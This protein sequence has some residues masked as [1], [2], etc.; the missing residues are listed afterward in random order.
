MNVGLSS[1]VA[2]AGRRIMTAQT[3]SR[4]DTG[5]GQALRHLIRRE[6]ASVRCVR[7][8]ARRSTRCGVQVLPRQLWADIEIY[9]LEHVKSWPRS[10]K[11]SG[12]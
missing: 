7:P 3:V 2:E 9:L 1:Q 6:M 11:V 12:R 8:T 5:A 10:R 4:G